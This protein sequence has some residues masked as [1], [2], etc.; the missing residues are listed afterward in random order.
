MKV[1]RVVIKGK[2]EMVKMKKKV[3]EVWE[4]E[5]KEMKKGENMEDIGKYW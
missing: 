5:K 1:E 4:V 2:N 3:E